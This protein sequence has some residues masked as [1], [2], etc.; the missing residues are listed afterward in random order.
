MDKLNSKKF[1]IASG[2]TGIIVY[3]LCFLL[4]TILG[5]DALGKL[6]NLL[7]HGIDFSN[8]LRM[9]I[10][11]S[12]TLIGIVVSFFFWGLTGYLLSF[13]YNKIKD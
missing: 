6:A 12:E 2:I 11:I 1:G 13:F 3:I 8:I 4:M 7:F 10:Q 5:K 9:D